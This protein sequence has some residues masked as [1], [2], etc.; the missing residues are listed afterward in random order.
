MRGNG[1]QLR[2]LSGE[3][4]SGGALGSML[5]NTQEGKLAAETEGQEEVGSTVG[6]GHMGGHR[7]PSAPCFGGKKMRETRTLPNTRADSS[8]DSTDR[9]LG[10]S[11]CSTSFMF[12]KPDG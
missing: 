10:T 3:V 9:I 12:L 2:A 8:T 6:T 11:A 1:V 7:G 5:F 4:V